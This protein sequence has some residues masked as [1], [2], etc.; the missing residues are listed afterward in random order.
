MERRQGGETSGHEAR[1]RTLASRSSSREACSSSRVRCSVSRMRRSSSCSSSSRE[2]EGSVCTS[3]VTRPAA[4]PNGLS[5]L[6]GSGGG[7][8]AG[9]GSAGC[10]RSSSLAFLSRSRE[11]SS[12]CRVS[13]S[14]ACIARKSASV[15]REGGLAAIM[16]IEDGAEGPP[17]AR[18]WQVLFPRGKND[19]RGAPCFHSPVIFP[20]KQRKQQAQHQAALVQPASACP[21]LPC[22]RG[23][24]ARRSTAAAATRPARGLPVASRASTAPAP[25]TVPWRLCRAPGVSAPPPRSDGPRLLR[26]LSAAVL[27]TGRWQRQTPAGCS[28]SSSCC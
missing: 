22:T 12:C 15:T 16:A 4:G 27:H 25:R 18:S 26:Q 9:S 3:T 23:D 17:R 20:A 1:R 7:K 24:R 6:N 19:S 5:G 14:S 13:R 10:S 21:A 2:E 11:S 28:S 8:D